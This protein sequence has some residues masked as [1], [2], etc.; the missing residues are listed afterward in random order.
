MNKC[1]TDIIFEQ[2]KGLSN[3]QEPILVTPALI[4]K[5]AIRHCRDLTASSRQV[6]RCL[7][8]FYFFVTLTLVVD[9][10]KPEWCA[11]P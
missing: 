4:T 11:C 8:L 6:C 7:F 2:E 10:T 5:K 3:T 9:G 1:F